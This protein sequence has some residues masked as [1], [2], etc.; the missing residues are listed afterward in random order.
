MQ[1]KEQS[2]PAAAASH[3]VDG[4]ASVPVAKSQVAELAS[5]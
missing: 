5:V 1:R 3:W 2:A 4:K